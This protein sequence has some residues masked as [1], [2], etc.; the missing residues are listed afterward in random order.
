MN[1]SEK[2]HSDSETPTLLSVSLVPGPVLWAF[3]HYPA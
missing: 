2:H 1:Q 3:T